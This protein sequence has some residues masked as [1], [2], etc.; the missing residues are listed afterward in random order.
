[1]RSGQNDTG[2][3]APA[4]RVESAGRTMAGAVSISLGTFL[5]TP[6][7]VLSVLIAA[8]HCEETIRRALESVLPTPLAEVVLAPDDGQAVYAALA[9]DYGGRVSVL[10][11]SCGRGPGATR[12][13][14][15]DAA[16]GDFITML[17]CDDSFAPGALDEALALARDSRQRMAFLRT[18][19]VD[20]GSRQ[21][22]RE[23]APA[24]RL[25][26]RAFTDFHG[27]IHAL[28]QREHWQPYTPYRISQD[29]L[30][31]YGLLLASG[32]SAALTREPYV[33]TLQ[34][35]SITATAV[36]EEFNA[37]YAAIVANHP[38]PAMRQLFAE[39]LRVGQLYAALLQSGV[40]LSF[41][42][43]IRRQGQ[44]GRG[45]AAEPSSIV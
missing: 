41:H 30:H 3:S 31:D 17:D 38:E 20:E 32:G 34:P 10:A 40:K 7:P 21:L 44:L 9:D 43:F 16:R 39:K 29:V 5:S 19:Y 11:S 18:R 36:Q 35:R 4:V 22:C 28:Y 15:F 26:L 25:T 13:R 27:S 1:M 37:E 23:L 42:E 33:Q 8:F 6:T 2:D 12:N 45:L 24:P 14:A